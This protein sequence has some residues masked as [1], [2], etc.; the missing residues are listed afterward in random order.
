MLAQLVAT[1]QVMQ[2]FIRNC[3]ESSSPKRAPH[4][5]RRMPIVAAG[6]HRRHVYNISME[7]AWATVKIEYPNSLDT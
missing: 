6:E 7:G 1:K 2:Y 3:S 4:A 5:C